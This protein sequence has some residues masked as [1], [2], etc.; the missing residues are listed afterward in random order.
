MI[1]DALAQRERGPDLYPVPIVPKVG[2]DI[3]NIQ[4]GFS[5][6]NCELVLLITLRV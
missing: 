6:A 5:L 3:P 2:A 1:G 4:Y